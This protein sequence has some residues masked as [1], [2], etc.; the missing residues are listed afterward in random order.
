MQV[1]RT[2]L[3]EF[4]GI[5]C[6]TTSH[7]I[8]KEIETMNKEFDKVWKKMA[9][10]ILFSLI[11]TIMLD[12]KAAPVCGEIV[13]QFKDHM[14]LKLGTFEIWFRLD[15]DPNDYTVKSKSY[16]PVMILL[17][18][19]AN[20]KKKQKKKVQ[21]NS[22]SSVIDYS[23]TKDKL[24][25][26]FYCDFLERINK[27]GGKG[28]KNGGSDFLGIPA[29]K[30]EWKPN[31]WHYLALTWKKE[32]KNVMIRE[33]FL[34]G[35]SIKTQKRIFVEPKISRTATLKI[36]KSVDSDADEK[37]IKG[38]KAKKVGKNDSGSLFTVDSFR[39]SKTVRTPE[40][41]KNSFEKG[42]SVDKNTLLMDTFKKAKTT[43]KNAG[44]KNKKHKK[45]SVT[46]MVQPDKGKKGQIIGPHSIV[47]GKFGDKAIILHSE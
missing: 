33:L 46:G 9:F 8:I 32:G 44:K 47:K 45:L 11:F 34:D 7:Y 22:M 28:K 25:L 16:R 13:Y 14:N 20:E 17:D 10:S 40:E 5:L 21:S 1:E 42:F 39:I 36:G 6:N 26:G 38:K 12:V 24:S 15:V 41:I 19:N 3:L 4:D 23:W 35:E 30:L 29:K 2:R 37:D 18:L 27:K 31:E 43:K